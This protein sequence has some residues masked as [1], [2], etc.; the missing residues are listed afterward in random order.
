MSGGPLSHDPDRTGS[1]TV[2]HGPHTSHGANANHGPESSPGPEHPAEAAE[3]T[4]RTLGADE[5]HGPPG[6]T[7]S[8]R[9][10]ETPGRPGGEAS[11]RHERASRAL[12]DLP[13]PR[14][15]AAGSRD[16]ASGA[17]A[18]TPRTLLSLARPAGAGFGGGAGGRG[19]SAGGP[20]ADDP[21]ADDPSA[22]GDTADEQLLRNL[23]RG[24]V[25]DLEPAE[26]ALDHLHRAIP[27]RRAR[28]RQAVVGAAAAALL[29][30]TAVPAF[31]HVA[32]SGN[33]ATAA[34][35]LAGHGER[36]QSRQ[37]DAPGAAVGEKP[38]DGQPARGTTGP[39]EGA[40]GPSRTPSASDDPAD[41]HSARSG[42]V[43]QEELASIA[44]LPACGP[45]QL[46]VVLATS[47]TA[48]SN[49]TVYGTFRIANRSA[50]NCSVS[51]AGTMGFTASGAA[52]ATKIQVVQHV[53]GDPAAGLP[54]PAVEPAAVLLR[55]EMSYEVQFA[56]VPTD[57]CPTATAP[58]P[59]PV[60]TTPPG[61]G[62]E[63]D[64]TASVE[65]QSLPDD[66]A[67]ADGSIAVTHTPEAGAPTV[68]TTISNAC[69]GTIYRTGIV[70][71]P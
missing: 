18:P 16:G 4:G 13:R 20:G 14:E 2:N 45:G 11:D 71:E 46:G 26:S 44:A 17:D 32:S 56:F 58:T 30:G 48:D 27:V 62:A 9:Y 19:P 6:S 49:G 33:A 7:P 24:A 38:S 41:P 15:E 68:E 52:D 66:A 23:L 1:G 22:V 64:Q 36:S 12:D 53:M 70:A 67:P 5:E 39:H 69:A 61:T 54:D 3:P 31:V 43:S 55:P 51:S 50:A 10:D 25:R 40:P 57:T 65:T 42:A 21:S 8:G 63:E 29:I 34:P 35:A 60:E 59:T 28:R 37:G 47:G